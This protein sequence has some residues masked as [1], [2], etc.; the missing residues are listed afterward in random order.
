MG[1][2]W[3]HGVGQLGYRVDSWRVINV[4]SAPPLEAEPQP[5]TTPLRTL[6]LAVL[7]PFGVIGLLASPLIWEALRKVVGL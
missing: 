1:E 5:R 6:A 7:A 4:V 2:L 3:P